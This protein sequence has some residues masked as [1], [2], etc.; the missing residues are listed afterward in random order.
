MGASVGHEAGHR[1]RPAA[2]YEHTT[3]PAVV[4]EAHRV[5]GSALFLGSAIVDNAERYGGQMLSPTP[6]TVRVRYVQARC[7]ETV[8]VGEVVSIREVRT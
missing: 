8:R 5:C 4:E 2:L 1:R 3:D 7:A 6:S